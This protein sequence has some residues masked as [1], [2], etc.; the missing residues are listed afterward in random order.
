M[1]LYETW[2][3][4][5]PRARYR[6]VFRVKRWSKSLKYLSTMTP[7]SLSVIKDLSAKL[8]AFGSKES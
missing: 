1:M 8:M 5:S 4:M 6:L 3:S 2:E 7:F